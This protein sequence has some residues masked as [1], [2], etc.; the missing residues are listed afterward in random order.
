MRLR[1]NTL[2]VQLD[3]KPKHDELV[4]LLVSS[5]NTLW[6]QLDKKEWLSMSYKSDGSFSRNTLWVQLD[7]KNSFLLLK[8]ARIQCRNTLWVQLDKKFIMAHAQQQI[9]GRNTL[10]VQLDKKKSWTQWGIRSIF[11]AILYEC[12]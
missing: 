2:W 5:R 8:I 10:W 12:N 9:I 7:K 4:S 11:V 3:K 6:V 1:R